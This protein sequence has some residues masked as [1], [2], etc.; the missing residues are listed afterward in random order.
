MAKGGTAPI[1]NEALARIAPLYRIETEIRGQGPDLRRAV[2][3]ART[4]PLVAELRTWLTKQLQ[5]V[6]A[7]SKMAEAI[8]YGL[9]HWDGL[10]RFLD[11]GR[12]EIDS[13]TIER[14]I[15]PIALNRKNALFASSP[16]AMKGER[17]GA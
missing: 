5:L 10:T 13:N 9:R 7:K 15:R 3:Q 14:S 8:R 4:Q 2:R 12:I 17:I 16:A 11:D 1:A 6:S